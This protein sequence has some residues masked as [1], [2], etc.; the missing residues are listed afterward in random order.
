VSYASGSRS[1]TKNITADQFVEYYGNF[2]Y[3]EARYRDVNSLSY[4]CQPYKNLWIL[5]IDAC[6]IIETNGTY[7]VKPVLNPA[8]LAWI[9][10]KMDKAREK[11]ITVLAMMHFDIME[12]YSL[13][14][15]LEKGGIITDNVGNAIALMNAGISLIFTGH[16]HAN[17]ISEFSNDGK[18]L[19]EIETGSLVTPPHPY[20][21]MTLDDNL[22][23][24]ETRHISNVHAKLPEG[25]DFLTYSEVT[26]NSR[27]DNMFAYYL[28]FLFKVPHEPALII[29]PFFTRA[30]KAHFAGD[31][32]MP[33]DELKAL[34]AG[35]PSAL[36]NFLNNIW[37]DLPPMDNEI[38]IKLK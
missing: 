35:T 24:I 37:T 4:I 29:A 8:T 17:D 3:K 7:S 31:E 18:T 16:F 27:L 34:P 14:N 38:Y 5:G 6:N 26:M 2:G 30:F 28:E 10:E 15:K 20:R 9:L 36:M 12:H 22:I 32:M 23:Q 13:Q 33:S 19:T 1:T 25:M 21:I 11:N